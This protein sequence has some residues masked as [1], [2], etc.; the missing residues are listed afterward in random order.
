MRK[1]FL[2]C[3]AN[4]GCSVRKFKKIKK[5]HQEF[6]MFSFE[7]NEVFERDI[8]ETG[9]QLIKKAVWIEDGQVDFH[10]VTVTRYGDETRKTGASTLNTEKS[11]W[12]KRVHK[13]VKVEK[14]ESID[15]SNWVLSNFS[16]EDYIV[17]K[18]DIEGSEYEVLDKMIDDGSIYYVN[19]LWIEFHWNKCGTP[20]SKHDNINNFLDTLNIKIDKSWNAM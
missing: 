14:V 11:E 12:N 4:D 6:E 18:M 16:K 3:G 1:I 5:D 2:D 8:L 15:F 13:E 19:E 17:L 10:V 9:T 7:P 20:K